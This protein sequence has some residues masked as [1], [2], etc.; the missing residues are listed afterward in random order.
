M[1]VS[2]VVKGTL[3]TIAIVIKRGALLPL[4]DTKLLAFAEAQWG[5]HVLGDIVPVYADIVFFSKGIR[6]HC[7]F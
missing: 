5:V 4:V 7:T 1:L 2:N 3:S 6:I